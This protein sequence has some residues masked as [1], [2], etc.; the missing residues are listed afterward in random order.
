MS[1]LSN[2]KVATP[3]FQE[4]VPSSKKKIT[5]KPFKVGDE[6]VL[7][8]ASESKDNKQMIRALKQVIDNCTDDSVDVSELTT[9]DLEYLFV[10]LRA[11]S[12]GENA[13]IGVKC[14]KCETTNKIS[15]DLS[16]LEVNFDPEH[17]TTVKINDNLGFEMKY[18]DL[19]DVSEV[20]D[21]N[22]DSIMDIVAK[23]VKTVY[24]GDETFDV[25]PAEIKDVKNIIDQLTT[26]QFTE[27][28]DFFTK[29]PKLRKDITFTCGSCNE[30]NE[31][32]L[33][34]LASF[35]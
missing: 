27:L 14:T 13:D 23:S 1:Q 16:K 20:S 28:Q 33:E 15:V 19:E 5:I 26:S 34:G 32:K 2:I 11:V 21:E 8:L 29:A 18:V 30:H 12:V 25:G 7:L 17:K 22:I 3:T 4:L 31:Q 9:Y 10:K 35:F 6:K 24:Y